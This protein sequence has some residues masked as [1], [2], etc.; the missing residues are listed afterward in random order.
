MSSS[1]AL[2]VWA[3]LLVGLLRFDPAREPKTSPALWVTVIWMFI[4]GSRLPSQWF[5]A[6]I[7]SRPDA[8]EEGN[9]LDRTI[10]SVLIALGIAI[11]MSR[12]FKWVEFFRR[13]LALTAFLC[14]ALVSILW[15]DYSFIALK[16]WFRDLGD[17]VMI[18]VVLSDPRPL[19]ATRTMLRRLCYLLI[20]LSILF[21]KY[22]PQLGIHYSVWTGAPEFAGVAT[23]KNTLGGACLISG[24]AFFWDTAT[25]WSDRKKSRE[26]RIILINIAFIAMTFWLLKLCDSATSR[27]CLLLG[28]LVIAAA[29]SKAFQRRPRLLQVLV[30][31][32]Y[33]GYLTL[34][35]GLGLNGE[36]AGAVGRDPT[37]TGRTV[38]WK[39][40]LST[41][42]NPLVGTGYESFWLGPRLF[43]VW[44]QTGVG[45][46]EA[47]NTYLDIYLNLGLIGLFLLL[48]FLIASYGRICGELR[49]H[50]SLGSLGAATWAV[51]IFAGT[52]EVVMKNGLPWMLFLLGAG[53][54]GVSYAG[55]RSKLLPAVA[56]GWDSTISHGGAAHVIQDWAGER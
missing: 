9:S 26:K 37:F 6:G 14:F 44:A 30:P 50:S 35:F 54:R 32:A 21:I 40:V 20:P 1:V 12:S 10:Y 16:R 5:G 45:I 31:A 55:S 11:L 36:L 28:C 7:M 2:L 56:S 3:I 42:T 27:T 15:S 34:A 29:H 41:R 52:T 51:I 53:L 22:Y 8:L 33:I 19:D 25:R 4:A 47:H 49:R 43:Q 24:L 13:N 18:L 23:S 46:N 48:S 38:I 39:A 17:Y